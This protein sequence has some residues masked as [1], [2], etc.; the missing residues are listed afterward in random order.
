MKPL[1]ED[2]ADAAGAVVLHV[3]GGIV[4][5]DQHAPV[6]ERLQVLGD[7]LAA[8][9]VVGGNRV[10]GRRGRI[11]DGNRTA[12]IGDAGTAPRHDHQAVDV[13][14]DQPLDRLGLGRDVAAR[15][16][17]QHAVARRRG[18]KLDRLGDLGEERIGDIG[19]NETDHAGATGPERSARLA[20]YV[21]ELGRGRADLLH[22]F[23]RH[24]ALAGE[25]VRNRGC[26]HAERSGNPR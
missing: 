9:P 25:R 22:H 26:G 20:R 19:K 2:G 21:T 18:G 8:T 15:V 12:D 11:D 5:D 1:A 17:N 13:A 4:A 24:A 23:G 16:R 6:P 10:A 7:L 3:R 14:V